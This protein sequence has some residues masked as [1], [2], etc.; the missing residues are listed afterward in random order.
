MNIEQE[1]RCD[2]CNEKMEYLD[3]E[4]INLSVNKSGDPIGFNK[5]VKAVNVRFYFGT[6][7]V[8]YS[9]PYPFNNEKVIP[10]FIADI[11]K[12]CIKF[13]KLDYLQL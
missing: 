1:T 6:C 3:H 5:F 8:N 7:K 11:R 12:H 10:A 2:I 9:K 4:L 13:D